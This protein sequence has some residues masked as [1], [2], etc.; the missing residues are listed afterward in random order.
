MMEQMLSQIG[1]TFPLQELDAGEFKHLKV[2]S[3]F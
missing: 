1:K 2:K 3:V